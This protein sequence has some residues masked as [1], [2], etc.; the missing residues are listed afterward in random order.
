MN[1]KPSVLYVDDESI[2]LR[3]FKL[4]F[5]DNYSITTASSGLEAL[6]LI[7]SNDIEIIVSDQRMPGMTGTEFMIE[8]KKILPK[9]KYILL[10]GYTDIEALEKAINQVGLWQF[11]KKPWEPSNLKFIIDNAY[12]SLETEKKNIV[13][14]AA[15]EQSEERLNLALEGTS[16]GVWDWNLKTNKVYFSPTWKHM[17][18]YQDDELENEIKTWENLLHPEDLQKSFKHLDNY[19]QGDEEQY[20]LEFRMLHKSGKYIHVLS[21]GRGIKNENGD[22]ER[23]TGTFIDLTEKDEAQN[24]IKKLNEEL[25]E[26]VERRTKALKL[27]NIQLIQRNKFEHLI[28]KISSELIG[29]SGDLVSDQID[30]ALNDIKEFTS[31]DNAFV[32]QMNQS[33]ELFVKNECIQNDGVSKIFKSFNGKRLSQLPLIQSKINADELLIIKNSDNITEEFTF[34]KKLFQESQISSLLLIPL[35]LK[36]KTIGCFGITYSTF[37]KDWGQEDISLLKFIAEIFTNAI[38]RSQNELELIDR[39]RKLSFANTI[40]L[41]NERKTKLLQNIASIANSPLKLDEALILCHEIIINQGKGISGV[42]IKINNDVDENDFEIKNIITTTDQEKAQLEKY[43]S[44]SGNPIRSL[45]IKAIQKKEIIIENNIEVSYNSQS[46]LTYNFDITAI[47]I[48]V[49]QKIH[50]IFISIFPPNEESLKD[51][52]LLNEISR[53]ISFV[54]ERDITKGE[55]KKSLIREKELGE[56]KSQFISMASHQFRT[57][58]TVIQANIE[59][60]QMLANQIDTNLQGK[61]EKI[62][63]RIQEEVIRLTSLMTDVLLLGKLNASALKANLEEKNILEIT[64][65]IIDKINQIQEDKRACFNNIIGTP[66]LV[67]IDEELF[68]HAYT[69]L[70]ENAFKYSKNRYPPESIITFEENKVVIEIKDYGRGIPEEDIK[71]LFQPFY[72][73]TNTADIDGTGLGL[74]VCKKYIELQNGKIKVQSQ[75]DKETVFTIELAL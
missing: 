56:L 26:R 64:Q 14:T 59:L 8:A 47:P 58:L 11:V 5:K 21:R 74:V 68:A 34:E 73:G 25:E 51:L 28:S 60:F 32:I 4:S 69:N 62:S 6:D 7:K 9:S 57:P 17:V 44:Q 2:N 35:K 45:V 55:L 19:F 52:P 13:I 18:G 22:F 54:A 43:L 66:Q 65:G 27:L 31:A 67:K 39:E 10:T 72:R 70:L 40:I 38:Q 30:K 36:T 61:F 29:T 63:V 3:L 33:K 53:E 41:D 71:N 23:L 48:I 24:H 75:E 49:G 42:L 16:A 20:E 1:S 15:L 37:D 50:H 46:S 12:S